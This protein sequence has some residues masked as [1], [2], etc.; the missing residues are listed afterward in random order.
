MI[1]VFLS[2][3]ENNSTQLSTNLKEDNMTKKLTIVM[4]I[5]ILLVSGGVLY[6]STRTDNDVVSSSQEA[7]TQNDTTTA[8]NCVAEDCLKISDL[9]YPV[10]NLPDGPDIM[11]YLWL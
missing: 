10:D 2:F 4:I 8:Q 9:E 11:G 6:V 1:Q 3:P 5:A 7:A